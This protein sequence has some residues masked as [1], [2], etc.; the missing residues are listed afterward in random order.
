MNNEVKWIAW[1]MFT[2]SEANAWWLMMCVFTVTCI[3]LIIGNIIDRHERG[4]LLDHFNIEQPSIWEIVKNI[5]G[6]FVN[7]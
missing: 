3:T 7:H 5:F 2:G 4:L 1:E 6:R